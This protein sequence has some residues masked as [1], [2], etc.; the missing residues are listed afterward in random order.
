MAELEAQLCARE[1]ALTRAQA[2]S[3]CCAQ[4]DVC[5]MAGTVS[6][7]VTV[8]LAGCTGGAGK[9]KLLPVLAPAAGC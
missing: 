3:T 8:L 1:E 9:G 7:T 6:P 2:R 5:T 4:A